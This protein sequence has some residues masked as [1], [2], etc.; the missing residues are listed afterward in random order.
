MAYACGTYEMD[1]VHYIYDKNKK[2]KPQK[3]DLPSLKNDITRI[4]WT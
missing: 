3:K 4:L 1:L 2:G